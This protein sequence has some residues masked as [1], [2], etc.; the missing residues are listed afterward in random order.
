MEI[1]GG[2]FCQAVRYEA[3]IDHG[4]VGVCHCRDCQIF[5]GSAFRTAGFVAPEDF[6]FSMGEPKYFVK[7]GDSGKIRR[8]AFCDQCGTHLCSM[9][10]EGDMQSG[11]ISLRISSSDQFDQVKPT[12]ELYCASRVSWLKPMEGTVEFQGMP[13]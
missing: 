2:C 6:A 10:S 11:Y 3:I 1:T 13:E 4:R 7:T 8:M 5:S 9:P 12:A